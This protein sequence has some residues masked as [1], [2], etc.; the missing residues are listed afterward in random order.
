MG[1]TRLRGRRTLASDVKIIATTGA[2]LLGGRQSLF[3]SKDVSLAKAESSNFL[4]FSSNA[5]EVD[6]EQLSEPSDDSE[7]EVG[8]GGQV[9]LCGDR[10]N[11]GGTDLE[12][13]SD[14]GSLGNDELE[15]D[16]GKDCG[17]GHGV[18]GEQEVDELFSLASE[19]D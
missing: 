2:N 18:E 11:W 1:W 17:A 14:G 5:A 8:G 3:Q 6:L 19:A 15:Q 12:D 13:E 7:V 9:F 4:P 16:G 10:G